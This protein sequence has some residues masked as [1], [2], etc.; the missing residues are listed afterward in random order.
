MEYLQTLTSKG[1]GKTG[2]V[3]PASELSDAIAKGVDT[4][5]LA[6]GRPKTEAK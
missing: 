4:V 2:Y 1:M 6:S 5:S 3:P